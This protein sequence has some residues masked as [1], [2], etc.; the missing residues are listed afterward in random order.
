MVH[1]VTLTLR[2][3]QPRARLAYD[4]YDR[5]S[6][7]TS[8]GRVPYH[9]D[10]INPDRMPRAKHRNILFGRNAV[11]NTTPVERLEIWQKFTRVVE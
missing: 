7:H 10:K 11:G 3:I 4:S 6:Q 2:E 1:G 9:N 8:S 5:R